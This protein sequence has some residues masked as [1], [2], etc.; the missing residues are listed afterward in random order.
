MKNLSLIWCALLTGAVGYL[1]FK[2]NGGAT[3]AASSATTKTAD[4]KHI[5]FVNTDS[6]LTKYEFFKD[7]QKEM[8]N[9]KYRL[10]VDLGNKEKGLRAEAEALQARAGAMTEAERQ[11]AAL[12]FQKKQSEAAQYAQQQEG[13][14][15]EEISKKNREMYERI[16]DYVKKYNAEN[17]YEFVLGYTKV[18][19]GILFADESV[20]VTDK[21]IEGL[22]KAYK[23]NKPAD[24]K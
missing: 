4:G 12:M 5:V 7:F 22:N 19:G 10:Q 23:E 15:G 2:S 21:I 16:Q 17:K 20:D 9:K 3:S 18:G 8:E 24:K 6:L 13:K 14:L 1:L 11:G